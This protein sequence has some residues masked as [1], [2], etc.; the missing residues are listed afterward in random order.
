MGDQVGRGLTE[1]LL[2]LAVGAE[3]SNVITITITNGRP[4]AE[5]RVQV[6]SAAGL[7][8]LAAAMHAGVKAASGATAVTTD[9]NPTLHFT[10]GTS[11]QGAI[12]ITDVSAALAAAV[13]VVFTPI[14]FSGPTQRQRVTFA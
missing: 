2:T 9:D 7:L 12:E 5:Y 8:V 1:P 11:G 13:E 14:S 3:A 6:F 10:L 4:S